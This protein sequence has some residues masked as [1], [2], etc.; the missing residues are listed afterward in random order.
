MQR[1]S[2]AHE[3]QLYL[4]PSGAESLQALPP[5]DT[6]LSY[7]LEAQQLTLTFA[8]AISPRSIRRSTRR[9]I[10]LALELLAPKADERV[11]DLFC[12]LGNFTLALARHA[13]EVVG[14]EAVESMVERGRQNARLNGLDNVSFHAADLTLPVTK[15][16]WWG[17]GFDKILLDPPRA[18]AAELIEPLARLGA[19][20]ILY[21]SCDPATLARDAGQLCRQGYRLRQWGVMNMFPHTTHVESI[22]LFE[23]LK[24]R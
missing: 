8:P 18:G 2:Q 24:S 22:A 19:K 3:L 21:I 14:I 16:A 13:A 1:L 9:L 15:K 6:P 10:A 11:L 4:Q 5:T 17:R 12:G 7:Q 23:R 20:Q